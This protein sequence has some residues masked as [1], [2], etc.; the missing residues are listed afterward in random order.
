MPKP[1]FLN[2]PDEKRNRIVELAL[3]EFST[4]PYRQASLSRIVARAGI[5]KGSMYQY[6]DNKL[7]LY[8]WLVTEEVERR[9][10]EWLETNG[11]GLDGRSSGLFGTLER[12]V[13]T[14]VGFTLAHPRLA[15]LAA[16]A[17]EPTA[18]EELRELHATLR[19]EQI[20]GLT[21]QIRAAQAAGEIRSVDARPL[22]H[23]IDA[24]IVRGTTNAVLDR[25]G[26]GVHEFLASDRPTLSEHEWRAL[27][28]EA[29]DLIRRGIRVAVSETLQ[30]EADAQLLHAS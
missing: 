3:D 10:K 17:M 28:Q 7:D 19:R 6:F 22:A 26:L 20:D 16:S 23:F 4:H 13:L 27:V 29:L 15:R 11:I 25:L 24:L 2:L 21:D 8:Q 9:R 14:G 5:A 30:L 12:M 18:D 1:T